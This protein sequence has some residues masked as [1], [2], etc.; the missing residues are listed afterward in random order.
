MHIKIGLIIIIT[1]LMSTMVSI[2]DLKAEDLSRG[3]LNYQAIVTG[4]KS[5]EQLTPQEQQEVIKVYRLLKSKSTDGKS[6]ECKDALSRAESAASELADY[7][8]KLRNC[9][10]SQ[11]Y[12]DDC[13][14]E[15]R[16]VKNAY[17]DY[18]D[19]ISSVNS[20]CN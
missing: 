15:F 8:R 13:S 16:R 17:S 4:K 1:I 3:Y 14:S 20:Y 12:T 10:E 19:A 11:D 5:F 7:A 18:E 2:T 9:A 6:S